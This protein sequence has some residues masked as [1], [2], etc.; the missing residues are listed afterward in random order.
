MRYYELNYLISLEISETE[1]KS[2][3]EEINA[4]IVEKEGKVINFIEPIKIKLFFPI[5]SPI[6]HTRQKEAYLATLN[7]QLNPE[8]LQDIERKLKSDEKILRYLLITQKIS[9][10]V[11]EIPLKKPEK[12]TRPKKVEL[13]EIEQKLEEILGE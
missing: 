8:K 13:K 7:F 4:L 10:K 9:K 6:T 3:T 5:K 12:I 2:L 1:L 11:T